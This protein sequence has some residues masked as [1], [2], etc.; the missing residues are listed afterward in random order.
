MLLRSMIIAAALAMTGSAA[1]AEGE[2]AKGDAVNGEKVF[3]K[4]AACHKVGDGAKNG[5]GPVQNGIVGRKSG[6]YEGFSYS[7]INKAA[8]EAGL[9]WTPENMFTYLEDP[10]AFLKKF[11]TDAKKP[12]LAVGSTKMAFKL[13]DPVERADVIAYLATLSPPAAAAPV[14]PVTP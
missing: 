13:K 12:E 11:L 4:C 10:N 8:G 1:Q 9:I 7:A 14:A 5:V 3:K 6:T 2:L